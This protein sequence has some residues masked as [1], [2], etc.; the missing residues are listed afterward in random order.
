MIDT[1]GDSTGPKTSIT[2][3]TGE[4]E[5]VTTCEPMLGGK[6]ALTII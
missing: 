6:F 5:S 1:K 4:S 3:P 2:L